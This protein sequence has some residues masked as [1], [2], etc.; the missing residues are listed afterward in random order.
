MLTAISRTCLWIFSEDVVAL[1]WECSML[2]TREKG[3]LRRRRS[4]VF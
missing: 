2:T 4:V 1:V 3:S